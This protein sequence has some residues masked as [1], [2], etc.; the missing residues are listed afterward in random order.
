MWYEVA[1]LSKWNPKT[2]FNLCLLI[3]SGV[4]FIILMRL[5]YQSI[6]SK[7]SNLYL[8]AMEIIQLIIV[9]INVIIYINNHVI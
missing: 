5:T 8:N 6:F 4:L 1:F 9:I 3:T 2:L 7:L